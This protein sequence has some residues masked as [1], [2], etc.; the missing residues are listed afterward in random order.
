MR[1][2]GIV[3]AL[4]F[5][6]ASAAGASAQDNWHVVSGDDWC[7]DGDG[8]RNHAHACEVREVTWRGAG[9]LAVDAAPNG[10]IEV[11]AGDGQEVRLQAKLSASAEDEGEANRLL[12]G[13]RIQTG[14]KISADGP[15]TDHDSWWSVS[16]RLTV[17]AHTDLDL[18]SY[19]GGITLAGVRGRTEFS[20]TNGGV[21]VRDGGGSLH[22]HTTNGGVKVALSGTKWDGTGLDVTTTNGG[23]VLEIPA[24]YNAHLETSTV[25]GG[26]HIDFPVRV[27]GRLDRELSTDL[28]TGGP[29]VRAVTTNGGVQIKRR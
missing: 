26:V 1:G 8:D 11:T 2:R 12:S 15:R 14:G 4:L 10:G 23:V 16:Y 13:I 21:H 18:R 7:H 22:G 5:V 3:G 6:A 24:D 19:N 20:T 27:Q 9:P 28:G 17:P 29:T 25:N